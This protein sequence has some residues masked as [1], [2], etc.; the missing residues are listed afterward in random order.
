MKVG[1]SLV[2][3]NEPKN[4]LVLF[5]KNIFS[6][7]PTTIHLKVLIFTNSKH[8]YDFPDNVTV[9]NLGSNVG[10]GRG[11]NFNYEWF[12]KNNF[13]KIIIS[14]TDIE[15]T[16]NLKAFLKNDQS[17]IFGPNIFNANN[18]IQKVSRSLP[19]L[20]DKFLS[21]IFEYRYSIK[22]PVNKKTNVPHISGCFLVLN[23]DNYIKL[24]YDWLFDPGF[25]L[26]EEDTDLCRRIWGKGCV[27]IEPTLSV[28]H[29][30]GKGSS[31]SI[32]LFFIHL[33]SIILY[34]KKWGLL[35]KESI[36]SRELIINYNN[37]N[38]TFRPQ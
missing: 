28:K 26:Y 27:S 16:G 34:F 29:D 37:E 22:T 12:L 25:F 2:L 23:V 30:Y 19:T 6:Q 35:D 20:T 7:I 9:N 11:H 14:N 8:N 33:K 5:L 21:F 31:K 13:K 4:R 10:F 17:V 18:S 3:Y 32:K 38:S 24:N 36:K 15:I 1:L